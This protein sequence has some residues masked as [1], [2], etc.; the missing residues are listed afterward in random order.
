MKNTVF[1]QS[2]LE[3]SAQHYQAHLERIGDYLLHGP[4]VWWKKVAGGIM[5]L[6]E[7]SRQEGPTLQYFRSTSLTDV[8]IYLQQ[9]WEACCPSG[10]ELPAAGILGG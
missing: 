8:Q 4:G 5:F 6:E 2:L 9:Q 10:V 3:N 7:L 1:P